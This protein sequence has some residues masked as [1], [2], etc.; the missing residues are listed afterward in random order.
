MIFRLFLCVYVFLLSVECDPRAEEGYPRGFMSVCPGSTKPASI[1]R[2][3]LKYLYFVVQGKGR[4]RQTYNYWDA[5][6]IATDPRIDFRRK[7]VVVAIG[8]LDSTSFPISGMFA[9]E[10]EARGY[11][12]ILIDNQRFATVHYYL[13]SRLMRPVG[14]HVA[15]IL[16]ELTKAGLDPAKTELIGFSLGGQTV[17]YIARNYQNMAGKNI[18]RITALEPAGPCFRTLSSQERLDAS[19]ADFVQVIHTNIDGYGMATRMGHVDF[20]V[21]G[22]EFQPADLNL[23]P[24]TSTCSHFRVLTLW[25]SSMK[26]PRKFIALKCNSIQEA[27]DAACYKEH[28]VTNVM[29]DSVNVNNHGIFYLSTS[30]MFP[31]YLGK[32]GLKPEYASWRRI[33]DIN[34]GNETEVYT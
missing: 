22:G 28:P 26:N 34:E 11:N 33:S 4:T 32:N 2:S 8:Y 20:Y 6:N 30:K 23:F 16:V 18:S 17:S 3:Q 24:C 5:K 12:V 7:T 19:N 31:Y 13:A 14:K 25:L 15:E 21:N 29:G 27:R 9:N 10:Y 1:P